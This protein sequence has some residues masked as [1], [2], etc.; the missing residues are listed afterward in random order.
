MLAIMDN[1]RMIKT[2]NNGWDVQLVKWDKIIYKININQ[3]IQ[4]LSMVICFLYF[5]LYKF[6]NKLL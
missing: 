5:F 6:R 4:A 1:I 3:Q 2:I